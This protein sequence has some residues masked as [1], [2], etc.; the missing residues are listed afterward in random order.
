LGLAVW[1][2]IF[3]VLLLV[4]APQHARLDRVNLLVEATDVF[5]F[6]FV[7]RHFAVGLRIAL[8]FGHDVPLHKFMGDNMHKV[9]SD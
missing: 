4:T 8:G 3:C 6:P 2:S 1:S 9:F 7:G 5:F